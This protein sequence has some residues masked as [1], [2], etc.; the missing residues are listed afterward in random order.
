MPKFPMRSLAVVKKKILPSIF[1]YE[2]YVDQAIH[3]DI[4]N[5]VEIEACQ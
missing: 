4:G 1:T 5:K 2:M 3:L